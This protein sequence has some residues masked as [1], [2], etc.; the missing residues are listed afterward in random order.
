MK[1]LLNIL[2]GFPFAQ[3]SFG[4]CENFP[5]LN[6]GNDTLLC[7][8]STVTFQLPS[9]YDFHSW[10]NGSNSSTF[11]VTGPDT[12][13]LSVYNSTPNLVT[14]GDFE[15]GNTGFTSSYVYGTGGAWG[16]L[17]NPGQYAIAT[18]PHLTHN[19]FS[20]CSD[21]TPTGVGNMLVANG[22]GTPNTAVW[23]Q[24]VS[25]SQNT[26]F[27]F[28]AWVGNALNEPNTS[29]LQFTINGVQLGSIFS[30]TPIA[31]TWNQFYET[32]NSGTST[33]A[34][35]CIVNQNTLGGGND[36]I[37]DD[38]YFSASCNQVDTV[39]VSYDTSSVNAGPGLT[40]CA[41]ESENLTASA[42]FSPASFTWEN[43]FNGATYTPTTSGY[44]SVEATSPFGCALIDSALVSITPMPW[45]IDLVESQPTS[46]GSND[47]VVYVTTTGSFNDPAYYTWNGPGA[48]N[49]TQI[50][51][52][53]WQNLSPGWYY[54]SIESDGCYRYDSVEVI[55]SN[56]PVAQ[57][58][59]TPTSGYG[60][61]SVSMTNS[62]TNANDYTWNFG[63]GNTTTATDESGQT[64][65]YDTPGSYTIEL[66]AINGLCSDTTAIT[67][68]VLDPPIPPIPPVIVPVNISFPNIITANGD[69]VNDLFEPIL[70]NIVG[71]EISITNRWGGIVYRSNSMTNFWDGKSNGTP[72]ND[73]VYFY[74]YTAIGAQGEELK[75]QGQ[76]NLIAK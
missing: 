57:L 38:I 23:C 1:L 41:N 26:N 68:V 20:I 67:I 70:L 59:A 69:Q 66:V 17:S 4:Q 13:I 65:V 42:N 14:N 36:F 60:P 16:L 75:G 37:I 15:S 31:C 24:S 44:Y 22:S 54:L 35:L 73:G 9:G 72:L 47:G 18:S 2:I 25:V 71:L 53:V 40:F 62:S 11:T 5:I 63:N 7:Q 21:H 30:T 10:Q 76:V 19:N 33:T 8:G 45:N 27:I 3:L 12:V 64:Q 6:L 74:T 46:C 28:S 55:I 50:N 52:S 32:W 56:P 29:D 34:Q 58:S 43:T 61:L 49:P 39:I 51:A 48:T